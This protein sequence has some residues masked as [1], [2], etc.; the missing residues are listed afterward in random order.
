[1][2][3]GRAVE[4]DLIASFVTGRLGTDHVLVVAGEPGVGKSAL[5]DAG[6]EIAGRAGRR[7]LRAAA[8]EYEAE[9]QFGALNQLLHPLAGHVEDLSAEHRHALR[10][11]LGFETGVP[12][13]QLIAGA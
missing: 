10:V 11:V 6:A 9:L 1:M 3:F 7:V 13:S 4:I 8:L 12:P 2:L 5:L